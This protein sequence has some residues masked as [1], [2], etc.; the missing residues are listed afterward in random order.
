MQKLRL[1]EHRSFRKKKIRKTMIS[2]GSILF[3]IISALGIPHLAS[4]ESQAQEDSIHSYF[5][6][7]SL[8]AS[9]ADMIAPAIAKGKIHKLEEI[10]GRLILISCSQRTHSIKSKI[11]ASTHALN[12]LQL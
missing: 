1:S 6:G 3:T 2:V 7:S 4:P 8:T 10:E 9:Y 11:R 5:C 12:G